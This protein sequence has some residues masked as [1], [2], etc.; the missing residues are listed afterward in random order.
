[1]RIRLEFFKEYK[2]KK[3][4]ARGSK[5][6]RH[7]RGL[8][9]LGSSVIH[10]S[11]SVPRPCLYTAHEITIKRG[12]NPRHWEEDTAQFIEFR[13]VGRVT[14]EYGAWKEEKIAFP[15]RHGGGRAVETAS[16][17]L[18]SQCFLQEDRGGFRGEQLLLSTSPP[19]DNEDRT[20]RKI[21]LFGD[22]Y[23]VE[24]S[25]FSFLG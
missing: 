18:P 8:A 19:C 7:C 12:E 14:N 23:E 3:I 4:S 16:S 10:P 24:R 6:W 13:G 2:K 15:R 5:R 25:C 9:R 20:F 11:K 21:V 1:M 17:L 22:S